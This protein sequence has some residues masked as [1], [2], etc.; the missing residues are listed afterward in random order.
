MLNFPLKSIVSKVSHLILDKI[1]EAIVEIFVST[2]VSTFHIFER[3]TIK[4][5]T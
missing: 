3:T 1:E 4:P 5:F 2:S